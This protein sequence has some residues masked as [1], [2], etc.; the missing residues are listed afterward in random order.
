VEKSR[1]ERKHIGMRMDSRNRKAIERLR[2][3]LVSGDASTAASK[4]IVDALR[5]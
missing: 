3:I 1:N 2:E 4:E 5:L